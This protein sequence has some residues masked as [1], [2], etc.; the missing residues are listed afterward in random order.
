M[1]KI[2][3]A[4]IMLIKFMVEDLLVDLVSSVILGMYIT[5]YRQDIVK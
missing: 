5:V 4:L 1:Q 3:T 2:Y